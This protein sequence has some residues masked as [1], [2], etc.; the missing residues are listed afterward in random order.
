MPSVSGSQLR[1]ARAW[2]RK[3]LQRLRAIVIHLPKCLIV[4]HLLGL[5][6]TSMFLPAQTADEFTIVVLPDTQNYSE[7]YPQIFRAQTEWIAANRESRNIKLVLGLGDIV[8]H[9]SSETE[10]LNADAAIDLLDGA[11]VPYLL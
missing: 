10:W 1:V 9:G 5:L 3:Q 4:Y 8:N 11:S 7:F 6:L 2:V